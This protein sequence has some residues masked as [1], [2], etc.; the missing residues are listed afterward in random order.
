MA[1]YVC[2]LQRNFELPD[3][4]PAID[5]LPISIYICTSLRTLLAYILVYAHAHTYAHTSTHTCAHTCAHTCNLE[6]CVHLYQVE[7]SAN[8]ANAVSARSLVNNT[9]FD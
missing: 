9:F 8:A 3:G 7:V 1:R 2:V 5:L 6:S 4:Q